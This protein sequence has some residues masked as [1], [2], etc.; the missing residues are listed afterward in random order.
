MS[1][2][3]FLKDEMKYQGISAKELSQ[4]SGVNK[5]TID[6]YLLSKAQ[7]PSVTNAYKIAQAL[8]VSVEYLLTGNEINEKENEIVKSYNSLSQ[9][10][11]ELV[12]TLLR[13]MEKQNSLS[14]CNSI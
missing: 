10:Q 13:T 1:F 7:E 8:K 4:K 11:K 3:D 12:V 9:N 6:H 5:R 14:E 2:R